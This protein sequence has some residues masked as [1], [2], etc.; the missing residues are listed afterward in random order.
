MKYRGIPSHKDSAGGGCVGV[1][2]ELPSWE[3]EACGNSIQVS[4]S[5]FGLQQANDAQ[6]RIKGP[7]PN[8]KLFWGAV[9]PPSVPT[10]YFI[11]NKIKENNRNKE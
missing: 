2:Q 10:S 3:I 11:H 7:I 8:S 6:H 9:E 5:N 4:R 1:R